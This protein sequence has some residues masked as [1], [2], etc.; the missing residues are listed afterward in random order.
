MSAQKQSKPSWKQL[1]E[2]FPRVPRGFEVTTPGSEPLDAYERPVIALNF[3]PDSRLVAMSGGGRIPGP[4]TIRVCDAKDGSVLHVC[5]Y[6][7][8]GVFDVSYHPSTGLLASSSHDYAVVVWNPKK[9]DAIFVVGG[10]W[11]GVSRSSS[12]FFGGSLYVGDGMTWEDNRACL[13]AHDLAT[14]EATPLVEFEEGDGVSHMCLSP[15]Q[16]TLVVAADSQ[17]GSHDNTELL[18]LSRDGAVR[19]RLGLP[20]VLFALTALK[21]NRLALVVS[22]TD[23]AFELRLI[24]AK[25]GKVER[26][27]HLGS[28]VSGSLSRSPDG[29]R[30]LLGYGS[31]LRVLDAA[32][33]KELAAYEME[34]KC[35]SVA[36]SPDG[37]RL[38]AG[39]QTGG[40]ELFA[41]P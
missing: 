3:S 40:L 30:I 32:S 5:S 2:S 22:P 36:W 17:R 13:T 11:A 7:S 41:A 26:S 39:T 20:H 1:C 37:K 21:K 27:R 31:S 28:D 29:R 4:A 25:T 23:E 24:D 19:R 35:C 18:V 38:A 9:S 10:P 14:G 34:N 12:R 33:L 6:H 15:D 16:K 8:M